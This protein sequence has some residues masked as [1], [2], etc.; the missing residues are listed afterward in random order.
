MQ[1]ERLVG[2]M[3]ERGCQFTVT[4][5]LLNIYLQLDTSPRKMIRAEGSISKK[6]FELS[7]SP[8]KLVDDTVEGLIR[9]IEVIEKE[10][11]DEE[12]D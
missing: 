6:A 1:V 4:S 8:S 3:A 10:R 11:A 2:W 12:K 9:K 5:S 7:A